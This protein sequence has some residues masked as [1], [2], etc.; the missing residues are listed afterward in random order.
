MSDTGN[1]D[2]DI[3]K[4]AKE[5]N[6]DD[7]QLDT[8]DED[9]LNRLGF[10]ALDPEA[11]PTG[12]TT[13]RFG[14]PAAFYLIGDKEKL[15]VYS[16]T[17]EK[18]PQDGRYRVVTMESTGGSRSWTTGEHSSFEHLGS[19]NWNHYWVRPRV[20][21]KTEETLEFQLSLE[22]MKGRQESST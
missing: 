16:Y 12:T 18:L 9:L 10:V 15:T 13:V 4:I 7:K 22:S 11:S 5:Q 17:I 20:E 8:P 21:Q 6:I 3:K 14:E 1:V 2:R 19:Q